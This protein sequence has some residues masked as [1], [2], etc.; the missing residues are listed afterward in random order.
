MIGIKIG[1]IKMDILNELVK[2]INEKRCSSCGEIKDKKEFARNCQSKDGLNNWCKI[3]FKEYKQKPE[4]KKRHRGYQKIW[5]KKTYRNNRYHN[6]AYNTLWNHKQKG[7]QI[8]I[9]VKYLKRL[10]EKTKNC[11]YCGCSLRWKASK[12]PYHDSPTLE[13]INQERFINEGN[14][15]IIC[16]RCN[17]MKGNRTLKEYIDFCSTTLPNVILPKLKQLQKERQ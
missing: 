13:R 9:E 3:C 17:R 15:T 14:I 2:G 11:Q 16:M 6:W 8:N 12:R 10:A 5:R 4:N 1:V 7:M